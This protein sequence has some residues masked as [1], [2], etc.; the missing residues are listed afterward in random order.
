MEVTWLV[1]TAEALL[2]KETDYSKNSDM[3]T[4][5]C[6]DTIKVVIVS[7]DSR[8]LIG[9]TYQRHVSFR[10][11]LSLSALS[12]AYISILL[13]GSP[14]RHEDRLSIRE[15]EMEEDICMDLIRVIYGHVNRFTCNI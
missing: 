10:P 5:F 15:G 12:F 3:S 14:Q 7:Q 1:Q 9:T 8:L 6:E 4:P 2:R 13:Q 11:S